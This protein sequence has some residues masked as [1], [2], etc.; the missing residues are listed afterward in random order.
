[1][2][3]NSACI[4]LL[5]SLLFTLYMHNLCASRRAELARGRRLAVLYYKLC[6]GFNHLKSCLEVI[7]E[8]YLFSR[9]KKT[10]RFE[11]QNMGG[12]I[13]DMLSPQDLHP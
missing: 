6:Y 3:Y 10:T 4:E 12:G 11:G 13:K 8:H 1:M 5:R 9:T 7:I 2:S